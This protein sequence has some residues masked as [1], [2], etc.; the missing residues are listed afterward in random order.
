MVDYFR[1][2][3]AFLIACDSTANNIIEL[4]KEFINLDHNLNFKH[5]RQ[6]KRKYKVYPHRHHYPE[7]RSTIFS[8]EE[9]TV[10][11]TITYKSY[12][13]LYN[14]VI[15]QLN[16]QRVIYNYIGYNFMF[17]PCVLAIIRLSLDLS[18]N[19]AISGVFW[20]A[21]EMVDKSK[22]NL[23]MANTQGQNM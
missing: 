6:G 8:I 2:P 18:S 23:M 12:Y 19:Y 16:F 10:P 5:E 4:R 14:T 1:Y 11:D 15:K 13:V 21:W 7:G 20:G 9:A 3:D 22:D 17:R